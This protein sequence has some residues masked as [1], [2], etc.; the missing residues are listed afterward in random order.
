[1]NNHSTRFKQGLTL[2]EVLLAVIILSVSMTA[3]LLA[4]SRCIA[5]MKASA[6]YQQARWVLQSKQLEHPIIFELIED[7][8]DVEVPAET[9]DDGFTFQRIVEEDLDEDDLYLVRSVVSWERK[10]HTVHE[11]HIEYIWFVSDEE[12]DAYE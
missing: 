4:S 11:D 7:I 10:G 9:D 3:L 8:E 1:M 2:I 6:D 12:E 5:V